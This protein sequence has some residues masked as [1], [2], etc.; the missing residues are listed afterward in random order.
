MSP[1]SG[2]GT[3]SRRDF[4]R[5]AFNPGRWQII[6]AGGADLLDAQMLWR[7]TVPQDHD[8]LPAAADTAAPTAADFDQA[9]TAAAAS[10]GIRRVWELAEPELPSHIEPFSFVTVGLLRHVAQALD[11]SPG[12]TL[13][14]M[15]CGRGGPGL[16]LAR[17]ADVSLVGVDFSPVAVGQAAQRAALFGM[18]GRPGSPSAI[19]PVP[20][21]RRQAP[22]PPCRSTPSISRPILLQPPA[23]RAG[24]FGRACGWS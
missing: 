12:Q 16:W 19:S 14:D 17:E 9:F 8:D 23:K 11:L 13:A 10:P 22:T 7:W 18:A 15:G 3:T 6:T 2:G 21:S 4:H 24:C 5:R 20:G 1:R